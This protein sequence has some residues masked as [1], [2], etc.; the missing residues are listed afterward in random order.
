MADL[1]WRRVA[2][3][4]RSIAIAFNPSKFPEDIAAIID[5]LATSPGHAER[6]RLEHEAGAAMDSLKKGRGPDSGRPELDM[7]GW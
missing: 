2:E 3:M 1:S 6:M 5:A 7:A 4:S